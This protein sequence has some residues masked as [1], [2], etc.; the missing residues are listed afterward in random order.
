MSTWQMSR[1]ALC[2]LGAGRALLLQLG[3]AVLGAFDDVDLKQ[4]LRL[5][6]EEYPLAILPVGL[7]RE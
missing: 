6:D 7:P 3:G 5:T 4:L 2:F 1:E